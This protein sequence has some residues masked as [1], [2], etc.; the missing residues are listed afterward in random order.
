[1][2][3]METWRLPM[4][5]LVQRNGLPRLYG[6]DVWFSTAANGLLFSR[7]VA[8]WATSLRRSYHSISRQYIK[9]FSQRSLCFVSN[10]HCA[11]VEL[12]GQPDFG[13]LCGLQYSLLPASIVG[14]SS[15]R[16]CSCS[17]G[18]CR[19]RTWT[20][21]SRCAAN[22]SLQRLL[23]LLSSEKKGAL[24]RLLW[25][26]FQSMRAKDW[27]IESQALRGIGNWIRA[28]TVRWH[29]R[30]SRR[31]RSTWRNLRNVDS[32][33]VQQH[34]KWI[35]RKARIP[36]VLRFLSCFVRWWRELD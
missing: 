15:F 6:W 24:R 2:E 1:M 22:L 9:N 32:K 34:V 5:S 18:W 33:H 30:I 20:R 23:R 4:G 10:G 19:R 11:F 28:E 21:F 35:I 3:G 36:T 27:V 14:M 26:P 25:G 13:F 8:F 29:T 31:L 12:S 17:T 7:S 16:T